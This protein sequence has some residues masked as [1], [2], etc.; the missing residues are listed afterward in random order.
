MVNL[1]LSPPVLVGIL[2]VL[3]G[4]LDENGIYSYSHDFPNTN[5]IRF[6]I[7]LKFGN[8][9]APT[10]AMVIPCT[11]LCSPSV[12]THDHELRLG[13]QNI[14]ALRHSL[15]VHFVPIAAPSTES[16]PFGDIEYSHKHHRTTLCSCVIQFQIKSQ[17]EQKLAETFE[18]G[19]EIIISLE[20]KFCRDRD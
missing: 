7:Q 18:D 9:I 15:F 13:G 20:Q 10:L 3:V 8:R 12:G 2:G 14:R 19:G 16:G 11:Q 6:R 17:K 1:V 5:I 4:V